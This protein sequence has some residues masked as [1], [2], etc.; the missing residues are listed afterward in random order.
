MLYLFINLIVHTKV[1]FY[2]QDF[3]QLVI[4]LIFWIETLQKRRTEFRLSINGRWV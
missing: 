4:A 2:V 1:L 3:N